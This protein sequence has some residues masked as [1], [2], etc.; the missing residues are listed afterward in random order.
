MSIWVL[1]EAKKYADKKVNETKIRTYGVIF[2]G[3]NPIGIRTGD[4]VG[5]V[6]EVAVGDQSVQNDFD[7]VSFF[8]RPICCGYHDATGKFHVTA[9]RGE[10]GFA[11]DG[12]AG[13]VF[14][15]CTPFYWNGSFDAPSVTGTPRE[16]YELA[17]M[18]KTGVDKEYLPV[19][20][21][22][23]VDGVA[24]SRSGVMPTYESLNGH[25]TNARTY[26]ASAHTETMAAHMSEYVL[27][28]VEFAT[29]DLQTVMMGA[30]SLPYNSASHLTTVAESGVNRVIVS[31]ATAANYVVGQT[32]V[33]GTTQNGADIA[34]RVSITAIE[35]YSTDEKAMQFDGP[36]LDIPTGAFLSS[37]AW[38]NGATDVVVASSGSPGDNSS[39]KYPC[40]W[41]GKVDPWGNAYS[42]ISDVLIQ[43]T[44]SGEVGDPYVYTP[45]Y[46]P[47]PT[48]YSG[49]AITEDYVQLNYSIPGSDGYAKSLG[50]DPRYRH[51][52]LTNE[53]GASDT[54]YLSDYYYYPRYEVGVV[55]VGGYWSGGR[56]GGPVYFFCG[57]HPSSS[58]LYR[59]ARLFVTRS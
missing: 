39:G 9:Y 20:P 3:S 44:G 42:A 21:M 52:A 2:S 17:P 48:K 1:N 25:M 13:E 5:M 8:N 50:V 24:T 6:A 32:I 26:H 7:S 40:I 30:V 47:D 14:Y 43:R 54:T 12:S 28:L 34:D 19:Y 33:I 11:W 15:E 35:D 56:R 22:A 36:A 16:G 10:P 46:L 57:A 29:R 37:R 51:V 41:R 58:D 23:M 18:F 38:R 45:H 4:A 53:V 31:N 55:F 27:Q 59:L 49:G